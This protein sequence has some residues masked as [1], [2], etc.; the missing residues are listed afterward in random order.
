MMNMKSI[1]TIFLSTVVVLL[2]ALTSGVTAQTMKIAVP[3]TGSEKNSLISEETGRALFFLF[4]DEKGIFLEAMKNPAR[5]QS[6]GISR[7]VVALL[8]DKNVTMI[9]AVSFGDKMKQALTDHHINFVN[10]T[11]AA[12]DAVKTIIQ[13]TIKGE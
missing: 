1:Q 13:K 12:D 10:K 9:I 4:F 11:G 3:A 6:G 2:V 5:D 8:S 7:T